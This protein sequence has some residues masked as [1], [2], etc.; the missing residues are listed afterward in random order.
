MK[1]KVLSHRQHKEEVLEKAREE[2]LR[3]GSD[4]RLISEQLGEYLDEASYLEY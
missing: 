2:K 3:S 1:K 4:Q